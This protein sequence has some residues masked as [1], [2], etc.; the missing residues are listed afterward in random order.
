MLLL[1]L[2]VTLGL[3]ASCSN[4]E[5]HSPV[6]KVTYATLE[7]LEKERSRVLGVFL[8]GMKEN[9]VTALRAVVH[10]DAWP[11]VEAWL[12]ERE[13]V[14][15][16][17]DL[18]HEEHFSGGKYVASDTQWVGDRTY[19]LNCPGENPNGTDYSLDF[20]DLEMQVQNQ[21]WVVVGWKT[22]SEEWQ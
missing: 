13:P 9:D 15:C 6:S 3:G 17:A 21:T 1:L 2:V 4:D 7:P 5:S 20:E 19:F 11:K 14:M 22:V 8:I 18:F 16:R 12:A 10:S